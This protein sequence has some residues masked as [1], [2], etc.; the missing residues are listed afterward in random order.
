MLLE[1][2]TFFRQAALVAAV[3]LLFVGAWGADATRA[4][5]SPG[6]QDAPEQ[7]SGGPLLPHQAAYDVTYYDLSIA[8]HPETR[9]IEGR[10]TAQARVDTPI[11]R[12]VLDLDSRMRVDSVLYRGHVL[13]F[14]RRDGRLWVELPHTAPASSSTQVTVHYGGTP[15]V[16]PN[17]PWDGGFT[18]AETPSGQPWV[19]TSNQT[20]GPDL[21][22]PAKDHPTDEPDSMA[23]NV[24]VPEPLV[25]A[26]NGRLRSVDT[27]R[28]GTRTYHWFVSTP[29]NGYGVALNIAPYQTL[30]TTLT[31][32]AGER[33]PVRFFV[34]PEHV[35]KARRAL[36]G[37]LEA[38]RF[39]ERT[40]GPYPF[41]ANKLGIAE[42]PFLGMEHQTLIAYG[43]DFSSGG[44]QYDADFDAL[45]FHEFAHEWFANLVTAGDWKDFWIH[46]AFATY[47]EALYAEH[48][49]GAEGYRS[50][51]A[52]FRQRMPKEGTVARRASTS[53]QDMYGH[54]VYFRGA[55]VLNSLR[56]LMGD[57]AFF[58][59]L[60][61]MTYAEPALERVIDGRQTRIVDSAD[62]VRVA[63]KYFGQSLDWFFD[64]YLY[65]AAFP[66]LVARRTGSVLEL[67]WQVPDAES[68]P[69]PV[70]VSINGA[71]QRVA[72]DRGRATVRVP[73]EAEVS[74]D[75]HGLVLKRS[76]RR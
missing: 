43:H 13:P 3:V 28:S 53:A 2:M 5:G 51:L 41:R 33:V 71:V 64:V 46:E 34:L 57:G 50:L 1:N 6:E 18:W 10:L 39:L 61:R 70:P 31:S 32:I 55:L 72:M 49:R 26:S 44:L 63:E 21:W 4:Q 68:F 7:D 56:Y 38:A 27:T 8:V 30:D 19:G 54:A 76:A 11:D 22:W 24:T 65:E 9:T 74:V 75:P 16:A 47:L 40:L 60:R 25:A 59:A 52:H 15:R 12:F 23:I 69:M 36:P 58:Q 67:R 66:K 17:P 37:F 35:Q 20:A 62:I 73:K 14:E 45:F 42:A 29:I 48:L